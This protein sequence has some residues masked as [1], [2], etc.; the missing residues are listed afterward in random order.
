MIPYDPGKDELN[1]GK[2]TNSNWWHKCVRFIKSIND[3]EEQPEEHSRVGS[4]NDHV[5]TYDP[6]VSEHFHALKILGRTITFV[7]NVSLLLAVVVL[8]TLAVT[9]TNIV[10]VTETEPSFER[11]EYLRSNS[12]RYLQLTC[13]TQ[14]DTLTLGSFTEGIFEQSDACEWL[15]ANAA[16]TYQSAR[17]VGFLTV[18]ARDGF[19]VRKGKWR[20]VNACAM[21]G[22]GEACEAAVEMCVVGKRLLTNTMTDFHASLFPLNRLAEEEFLNSVI[23]AQLN[24]SVTANLASIRAPTQMLNLWA[25]N[26]IPRL[27]AFMQMHKNAIQAMRVKSG[28]D[29]PLTSVFE[30]ECARVTS[31]SD[32][33]VAA[34]LGNGVCDKKCNMAECLFDGGDCFIA[35]ES[36]WPTKQTFTTDA[37][38]DPIEE[39]ESYMSYSAFAAK[40]SS[41]NEKYDES[42]V[43][44]AFNPS[45]ADGWDVRYV[46]VISAPANLHASFDTASVFS[47]LGSESRRFNYCGNPAEW[48]NVKVVERGPSRQMSQAQFAVAFAAVEQY[49]DFP[50]VVA[51]ASVTKPERS[52]EWKLPLLLNYLAA[53]DLEIRTMSLKM[54]TSLNSTETKIW[55]QWIEQ[56]GTALE[57]ACGDVNEHWRKTEKLTELCEDLSFWKFS[58]SLSINTFIMYYFFEVS[59]FAE[60]AIENSGSLYMMGLDLGLKKNKTHGWAV[61]PLTSY[62]KYFEYA[63]VLSC[64]YSED[65]KPSLGMFITVLLGLYGGIS[66]FAQS[67][68]VA[69]YNAMRVLILRKSNRHHHQSGTLLPPV[70]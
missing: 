5:L 42:T 23:K 2:S 39:K 54:F 38:T 13:A 12:E 47:V 7:K 66:V 24:A 3:F 10:I 40:V 49:F 34:D 32:P 64:T 35:D 63:N 18:N 68:G 70:K 33:C 21:I 57:R 28:Q 65:Q 44:A 25:N 20:D 31:S 43:N 48:S 61:Y 9:R 60:S 16:K 69:T 8:A 53:C 14:N 36:I 59:Y 4:K 29:A 27:G 58:S 67:V 30:K 45:N 15:Y 26:N 6:S 56:V 37:N 1:R 62:E 52:G 22:Q 46:P 19:L 17:D 50:H 51:N 41:L 11:Y 55:S